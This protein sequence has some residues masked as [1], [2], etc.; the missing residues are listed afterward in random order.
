MRLL[1]NEDGYF[2]SVTAIRGVSLPGHGKIGFS[3]TVNR[4]DLSRFNDAK[5]QGSPFTLVIIRAH[6]SDMEWNKPEGRAALILMGEQ[7]SVNKYAFKITKFD[8]LDHK[9]NA[10]LVDV[11]VEGRRVS[12][13]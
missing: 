9:D 10:N 13:S 7:P 2:D 1:K 11:T 12:G 3:F 6:K 5:V 8:F 4:T